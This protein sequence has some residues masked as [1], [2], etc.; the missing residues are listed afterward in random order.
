MAVG[1]LQS[2]DWSGSVASSM[3]GN[4]ILERLG[5]ITWSLKPHLDACSDGGFARYATPSPL[6]RGQS[7]RL[8]TRAFLWI[9]PPERGAEAAHPDV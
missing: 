3:L 8:H 7:K 2:I 5:A 6:G 1:S 9:M 4:R